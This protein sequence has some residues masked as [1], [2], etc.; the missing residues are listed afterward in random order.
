MGIHPKETNVNESRTG[1][2]AVFLVMSLSSAI[3]ALGGGW[4]KTGE[5]KG[6]TGYARPAPQSILHEMM[7]VGMVEAPVTDI[8]ALLRDIPAQKDY[9]YLCSDA[10]LINFPGKTN[11]VDSYCIYSKMNMPAPVLD[12]D[13]IILW[14]WTTER[15]TGARFVHGEG[16]R[17]NYRLEKN[18]VRMMFITLDFTLTPKGPDKTEVTYSVLMNPVGTLP[19]SVKGMLTKN[20]AMKT[21]LGIRERVR[22]NREQLARPDLGKPFSGKEQQP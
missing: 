10:E 4:V 14:D 7:A 3:F 8:E 12:R 5:S 22:R 19:E 11:T 18:V 1:F 9:L 13:S 16:I 20:L 21:L 17:T 15:S 2:L 6:V